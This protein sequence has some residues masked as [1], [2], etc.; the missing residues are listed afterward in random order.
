MGR[1]KANRIKDEKRK[2]LKRQRLIDRTN[3]WA[4]WVGLLFS[5]ILS[6]IIVRLPYI[7]KLI[8]WLVTILS[9]E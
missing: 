2:R 9:F 8:Q 3:K 6:E 5:P 1:N 4:W 7:K